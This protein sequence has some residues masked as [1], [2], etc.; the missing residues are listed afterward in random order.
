MECF[1]RASNLTHRLALVQSAYLDAQGQPCA[2]ESAL[3]GRM[4][5]VKRFTTAQELNN[6]ACCIAELWTQ[7]IDGL[8]RCL[9][10]LCYLR[11]RLNKTYYVVELFKTGKSLKAHAEGL[12]VLSLSMGKTLMYCT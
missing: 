9:N 4:V 3:A 5:M 8:L 7:N 10:L 1:W 12:K 2:K 6:G 11:E